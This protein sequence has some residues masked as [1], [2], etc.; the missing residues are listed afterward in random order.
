[1]LLRSAG[2]G[3]LTLIVNVK[4][5]DKKQLS[6]PN[7]SKELKKA[8]MP[9]ISTTLP[10]LISTSGNPHPY[11]RLPPRWKKINTPSS[12]SIPFLLLFLNLHNITRAAPTHYCHFTRTGVYLGRYTPTGCLD[13]H[14]VL[15]V[16]HM[17]ELER[18]TLWDCYEFI[19]I[20]ENLCM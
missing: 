18:K 2:C 1:M 12:P 4:K 20:A 8:Y 16:W 14:A 15:R 11:P 13:V 6:R 19:Q 5:K 10:G 3:C 17:G 9:W 7:S